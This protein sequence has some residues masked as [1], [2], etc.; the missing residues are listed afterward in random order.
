MIET[1]RI[2][3]GLELFALIILSLLAAFFWNMIKDDGGELRRT[4]RNKDMALAGL[5]V[6]L[7]IG[8][9]LPT[10]LARTISFGI[11]CLPL[12]FFMAKYVRYLFKTLHG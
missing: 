7:G 5:F 1:I 11:T 6:G 3:V 9:F 2:I 8:L 12:I 4:I 10:P